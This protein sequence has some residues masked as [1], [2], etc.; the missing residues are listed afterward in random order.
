MATL[1]GGDVQFN[2]ISK[3]NGGAWTIGLGGP[4]P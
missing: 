3:S 2:Y 1:N 4:A